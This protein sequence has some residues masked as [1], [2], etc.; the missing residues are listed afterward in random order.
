MLTGF[1]F[2]EASVA[3]SAEEGLEDSGAVVVMGTSGGEKETHVNVGRQLNK[4]RHAVGIDKLMGHGDECI[5][6]EE[7]CSLQAVLA[8]QLQK[9]K[10]NPNAKESNKSK[11]KMKEGQDS[12]FTQFKQFLDKEHS[13]ENLLFWMEAEEVRHIPDAEEQRS[14]LKHRVKAINKKFIS[15]EAKTQINLPSQMVKEIQDNLG[16]P[17]TDI[18]HKAQ[19]EVFMLM[20]RDVFPRFF[21]TQPVTLDKAHHTTAKGPLGPKKAVAK[22]TRSLTA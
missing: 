5:F 4:F 2:Q 17:S 11:S 14:Y 10:K 21:K 13:V 12:V 8:E 22:I 16:D 18:F 6:E 19:Q 7:E 3:S 15:T 9:E 20:D 1:C